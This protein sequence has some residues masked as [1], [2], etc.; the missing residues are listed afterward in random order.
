MD[1]NIQGKMLDFQDSSAFFFMRLNQVQP[2]A[3]IAPQRYKN[4]G[5]NL[6]FLKVRSKK[7]KRIWKM[8]TKWA[9]SSAK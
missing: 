6:N 9:N 4:G 7:W 2:H 8:T 5:K 3:K 1:S